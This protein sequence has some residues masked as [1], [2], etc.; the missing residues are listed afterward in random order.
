MQIRDWRDEVWASLEGAM[1]VF[2]SAIPKIIVF[3]VILITGWF[4]AGLV[5]KGIAAL[6]WRVKFNDIATRSGFGVFGYKI[7]VKTDSAGFIVL[8]VLIGAFTALG[9]PAVSDVVYHLLL[10]L[11]N[12]VVAL[13]I[14]VIGRLAA[15]ALSNLVRGAFSNAELGN[16]NLLATISNVAVRAFVIGIAINQIGIS[17]TLI[18]TLFMVTVGVMALAL[19]LAFKYSGRKTA[20]QIVRGWYEKG[21]IAFPKIKEAAQDVKEQVHRQTQQPMQPPR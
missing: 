19:G 7:G 17:T 5:E 12:L 6:L 2:L 1:A 20:A 13:L 15:G 18:D 10:G 8:I 21:K 4:I 11:P 3:V 9:F 14:L 16:P